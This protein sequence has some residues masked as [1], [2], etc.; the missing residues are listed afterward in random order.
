[1]PARISPLSTDI[2]VGFPGETEEDFMDTV[3]VLSKEVGYHQ[4]FTFIYSKRR[5]NSGSK[6]GGRIPRTTSSQKRFDRLVDIVQAHAFEKNQ[7][8]IWAL[9]VP[10]LVEGSSKR[11]ELLIAGKSPKN[12]TVHAP[13]PAGKTPDQLA[14]SIVN[15]RVN[16]AKTWYLAGEIVVIAHQRLQRPLMRLLQPCHSL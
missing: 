5:G 6:H 1:M 9:T 12:Q 2:I 4:V 15:V 16:E 13:V 8:R 14:G 11:D 7:R 10:V 3:R